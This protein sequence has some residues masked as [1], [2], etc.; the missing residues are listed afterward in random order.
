M[1]N[2][3]LSVFFIVLVSIFSYLVFRANKKSYL[4]LNI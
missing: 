2:N 4:Q 1:R 3:F